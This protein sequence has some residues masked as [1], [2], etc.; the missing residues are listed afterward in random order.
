MLDSGFQKQKI[1][2]FRNPDSLTWGE[3][4]LSIDNSSYNIPHASLCFTLNLRYCAAGIDGRDKRVQGS[5]KSRMRTADVQAP[6]SSPLRDVS[7]FSR[8]RPS[9][10]MSEEKRLPF[11]G[12][13][14][15]KTIY[16]ISEKHNT[17][18]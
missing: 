12:K 14:N 3:T 16:F 9:A 13:Q 1:P 17:V 5:R 18:L 2:G 4:V 6:R 10:A 11:A 8:N 15:L 7:F